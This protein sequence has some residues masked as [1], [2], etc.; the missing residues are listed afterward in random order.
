MS[1]AGTVDTGSADAAAP[2]AAA[3]CLADADLWAV[4]VAVSDFEPSMT[5]MGRGE[6]PASEASVA[7]ELSGDLNAWLCDTSC[8]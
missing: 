3:I 6:G 7:N 4:G 2:A 5:T 1:A 8:V